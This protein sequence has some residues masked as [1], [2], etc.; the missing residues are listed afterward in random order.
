MK[1]QAYSR[2]WH[3][4]V[5]SASFS[6]IWVLFQLWE[7]V[8]IDEDDRWESLWVFEGTWHI[9]YFMVSQFPLLSDSLLLL[10]LVQPL[11]ACALECQPLI[12]VTIL[13]TYL[14]DATDS[15]VLI[16]IALM[17]R[18][19]SNSIAYAFSEQLSME[20]EAPSMKQ[21][22]LLDADFDGN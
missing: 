6:L 10:V 1:L 11:Y 9:V 3:I 18:P 15:Q 2:F 14:I 5:A 20:V 16:A 4:L 19:S 7:G 17:W 13:A 8:T 22:V 21:G 12:H